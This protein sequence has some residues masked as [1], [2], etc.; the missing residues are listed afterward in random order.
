[1]PWHKQSMKDAV[2]CD[3]L[4]REALTRLHPEVSEWGNPAGVMPSHPH[5]KPIKVRE[6]TWGTETSKYPE[7]KKSTEIAIV[8]ASEIAPMPKP[9]RV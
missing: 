3:N 6:M 5:P 4:R 8:A 7:E 2:S 9:G 1:M